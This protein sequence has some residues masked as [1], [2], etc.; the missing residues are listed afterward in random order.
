MTSQLTASSIPQCFLSSYY[1]LGEEDVVS[2]SGEDDSPQRVTEGAVRDAEAPARA[3][4][5][6][7]QAIGQAKNQRAFQDFVLS[8]A[9]WCFDPHLAI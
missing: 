6:R 1:V 4:Q 9:W 7:L 3:N 8:S 5:G 2:A